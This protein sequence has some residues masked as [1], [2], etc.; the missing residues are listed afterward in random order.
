MVLAL[1]THTQ[2]SPSPLP[3][4]T[5]PHPPSHPPHPHTVHTDTTPPLPGII[6]D[7][8]DPAA[9]HTHSSSLTTIEVT[10][11]NFR[12]YESGISQYLLT[13]FRQPYEEADV[14]T[15]ASDSVTGD[16]RAMVWNL[17]SF[18]NGDRIFVQ[19]DAFNGAGL[20]TTVNSSGI[21]IDLTPPELVYIVDGP[22]PAL[23]LQ[24]QTS[25]T[26]IRTSWQ[27]RDNQSGI[28]HIEGAIFEFREGR[29]V[30]IYPDPFFTDAVTESIPHTTS[31]WEMNGLQL[32]SGSKYV[33][34]LNFTNGAGL[35]VQYESNGVIVDTTPPIVQS[36][37]VLTDTY[38]DT[39]DMNVVIA[40]PSL[41]ESRWI[42]VDPETG[43]TEYLVGVVNE[44]STF[45][46]P[47][48]QDYISY[49]TATGGL[50]GNL[51][52]VPESGFYRVVV[53][54]VNAAGTRSEPVY[55]EPF[56]YM[57]TKF[58]QSKETLFNI[59]KR[60]ISFVFF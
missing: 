58:D 45:V 26:S 13:V 25:S 5:I 38:T 42:A 24:Y 27:V 6:F 47:G 43:I 16:Q 60:S 54:A 53:V 8:P 9:D 56:R 2:V 1:H 23:D 15:V 11:A 30:R 21:T 17:F 59:S 33:T 55:S 18:T 19:I 22:D 44:N 14:Q 31:F 51:A 50:I 40:N 39:V 34:M 20:A 3:T 57:Y 41:V 36:V 28:S 10:W 12:D 35:T 52:L 49:G 48:G 37:L 7:G 32:V 4:P 29:R 46:T